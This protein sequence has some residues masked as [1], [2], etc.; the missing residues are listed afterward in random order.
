LPMNVP[1]A[2]WNSLKT[3]QPTELIQTMQLPIFVAQG[4][5]DYQVTIDDFKLWENAVSSN[6]KAVLKSYPKLNHLFVKG[7]G[8]A[9]PK[10]Y[11]ERGEIDKIFIEDLTKFIL[12]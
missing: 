5:R 11:F 12:N 6:K 3:Y 9:T 8:K 2:Y 4:E 1:A 7:K 10:E